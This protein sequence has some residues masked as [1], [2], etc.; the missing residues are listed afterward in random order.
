MSHYKSNLRDIEFNLFEVFGAQDRLGHGPFAE[1][2]VETARDILDEVER[3]ATGPLAASFVDAD[4]N[5]PVYDPATCTVTMPEGFKASYK[6]LMDSG[7]WSLDLPQAP[8]RPRRPALAA[9]GR[10]RD[11]ARREPAGV[12]VHVRARL[13]RDPG[14]PRQRGAEEDRRAS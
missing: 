14:P 4:R 13:R 11:G 8:R 2:D 9:L 7:F 12:H 6:A 10:Q 5:P 3:L 1:M